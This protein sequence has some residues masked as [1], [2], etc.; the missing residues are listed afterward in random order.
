MR[1]RL[2]KKLVASSLALTLGFVFIP[3]VSVS[4]QRSIEQAAEALLGEV[5][6]ALKIEITNEELLL[7][8]SYEM[9]YAL[10]TGIIDQSTIDEL[11]IEV[12]DIEIP[13]EELFAEEE[14]GP[15]ESTNPIPTNNETT[16]LSTE[17]KAQLQT[18]LALRMSTQ[19][20]YWQ[21]I[22]T[23]WSSATD[24]ASIEFEKCISTASSDE[25]TDICYFNEQQQLQIFYAQQ[26]S[27]N[28]SLHSNS[29]SELGSEVSMLL[30]A[31]VTRAVVMIKETLQFLNTEELT[32][33]G[34]TSQLLEGILGKLESQPNGQ[35]Q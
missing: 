5:L 25:E 7:E 2:L 15:D 6:L 13:D 26:M 20:S 28:Y 1:K 3:Q 22:A 24:L 34:L 14:L 19:L 8:L 33:L 35:S 30:S 10:D 12:L 16:Q 4:A 27:E 21:V 29:A 18:R 23:D 17:L 31:S 9:Q 11:N 32:S